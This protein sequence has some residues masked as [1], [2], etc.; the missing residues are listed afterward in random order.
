MNEIIR[1]SCHHVLLGCIGLM[2][3]RAVLKA[4]IFVIL[5]VSA[6]RVLVRMRCNGSLIILPVYLVS[7]I[8]TTLYFNMCIIS[9]ILMMVFRKFRTCVYI[10]TITK[11]MR[12]QA[13]GSSVLSQRMNPYTLRPSYTY[14]IVAY[15][16]SDI[17]R[18]GEVQLKPCALCA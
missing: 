7:T 1:G 16:K 4:S 13:L 8:H 11:D 3:V 14:R 12:F 9:G 15:Y 5:D 6:G 10:A 17:R 18:I 2:S